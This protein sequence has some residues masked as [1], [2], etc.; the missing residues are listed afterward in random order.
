MLIGLNQDK[1]TGGTYVNSSSL[2]IVIKFF[3]KQDATLN[4]HEQREEMIRHIQE[5]IDSLMIYID[6]NDN[7]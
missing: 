5:K 2:L 4:E 6:E 7:K 1:S 3:V